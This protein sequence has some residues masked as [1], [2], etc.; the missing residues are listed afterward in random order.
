[1]HFCSSLVSETWTYWR[2]V[3][4]LVLAYCWAEQHF[5]GHSFYRKD[6]AGGNIWVEASDWSVWEAREFLVS[7]HVNRVS[8]ISIP[9]DWTC[10]RGS[11]LSNQKVVFSM[12]ILYTDV[13]FGLWCR[14]A[15][16]HELSS[17]DWCLWFVVLSE[18]VKINLSG[19]FQ[20]LFGQFG[21]WI[22]LW[23]VV[24]ICNGTILCQIKTQTNHSWIVS[25]LHC[26]ALVVFTF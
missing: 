25:T 17:K 12:V 9:S 8:Q 1:M 11:A 19:L 15:A 3:C 21:E 13:K 24:I 2:I 4:G 14:I 10:V 20:K 23:F 18:N 26:V 6:S 22:G 16:V 5:I 7:S